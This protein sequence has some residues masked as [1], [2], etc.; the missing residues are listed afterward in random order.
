[1]QTFKKFIIKFITDVLFMT[2]VINPGIISKAIHMLLS[3]P[4]YGVVFGLGMRS[5]KTEMPVFFLTWSI[6][7]AQNS[8]TKLIFFQS[9]KEEKR[10]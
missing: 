9:K 3:T 1:M 5:W 10:I 2:F 4:I 8:G 6:L 7:F